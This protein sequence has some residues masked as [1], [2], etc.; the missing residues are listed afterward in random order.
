MVFTVFYAELTQI[1]IKQTRR[2][3]RH[4]FHRVELN[5]HHPVAI[6][7]RNSSTEDA[8]VARKEPQGKEQVASFS[9]SKKNDGEA[10]EVGEEAGDGEG[11]SA[12]KG[13]NADR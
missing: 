12:G 9:R 5:R 11:K 10:R 6:D 13:L 8:M 7:S 1:I 2:L 3:A 4:D